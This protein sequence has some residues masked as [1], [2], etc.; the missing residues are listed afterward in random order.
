MGIVWVHEALSSGGGV[1]THDAGNR[2]TRVFDVLSDEYDD[3]AIT[4]ASAVDPSTSLAIPAPYSYFAKGH[5]ADY[6]AIV[7]EIAPER[8]QRHPLLWHVRVEYTVIRPNTLDG[9]WPAGTITDY[10]NLIL[11]DIRIWSIP[12]MELIDRDVNDN[13]LVNKAGDPFEP[14]PE[15]VRYITAIEVKWYNRTYDMNFWETYADSTNAATV[16][17]REPNTLLM[18]GMPAGNRKVDRNGTYYEIKG[19]FHWNKKGWKRTFLNAGRNELAPINTIDY[20]KIP[21]C[22]DAG[23][24]VRQPWPLDNAGAKLPTSAEVIWL[25][26]TVKEPRD[27]GPLNLPPL[28]VTF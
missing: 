25:E 28:N 19:E 11:P 15:D 18:I 24:P 7:T 16:W 9:Q 2:Y 14:R 12:V 21:I 8:D 17:G 26:F 4:I 10:I 6:G 27:W 5:D 13:P 1:G 22:D 3:N 20:K 23:V